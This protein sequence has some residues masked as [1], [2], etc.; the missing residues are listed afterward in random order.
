LSVFRLKRKK[1]TLMSGGG[2]SQNKASARSGTDVRGGQGEKGEKKGGDAQ[3]RGGR[4]GN[5]PQTFEGET[6]KDGLVPDSK[7]QSDGGDESGRRKTG[8]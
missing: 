7:G 4:G 5:G 2:Q 8:G 1:F 3:H 6:E